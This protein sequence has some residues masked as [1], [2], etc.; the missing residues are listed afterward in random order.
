MSR[1]VDP[2]REQFAAL[3]GQQIDGPLQML[4]LIRLKKKV[5][6]P[7][8][9]RATGAEAYAAYGKASAP[10]FKRVGGKIVWRGDFRQMVIGPADEM[11]DIAFIAQ[12]PTT[13]AFA[14]MLKDPEYQKAV[15][16][17][18][19]AVETSRLVCLTPGKKGSGF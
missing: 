4:N 2:T 3:T 7:S 1:F 12:Y 19:A 9:E 5:V 10:V 14:E 13:A 11:W 8:G 17:R 16:H 15:S 18:Q 6:Y